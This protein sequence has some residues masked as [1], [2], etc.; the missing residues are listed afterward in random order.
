MM[1][2]ETQLRGE[3]LSEY[4]QA[5]IGG[6][7]LTGDD[8]VMVRGLVETTVPPSTLAQWR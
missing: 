4:N 3:F 2:H 7:L 8:A 6:G 5:L 1:V